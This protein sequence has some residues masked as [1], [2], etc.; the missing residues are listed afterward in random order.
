MPLGFFCNMK[1]KE[2]DYKMDKNLIAQTPA[3]KRDN[4][5]LLAYNINNKTIEH[6]RFFN[7]IDYLQAGDIL[8]LNNSKVISARL[9]GKKETGGKVEVF[10][11]SAAERACG[12]EWRCLV[13][14]GGNK[15]GLEIF[16]AKGLTAKVIGRKEDIFT[17][18]FNQSGRRLQKTIVQI[19]SVPLPPYIKRAEKNK[20]DKKTYQTVYA[21][22][23]KSGS[24]AAPTAG[25]HFTKNILDKLRKKG[26]RIEYVTL[27]VGLGTFQPVKVDDIKKHQMHAEFVAVDKNVIRNIIQAK[28]EGRR[29]IA[30]GTTSARVLESVVADYARAGQIVDI[31]KEV[32]IFIYP[33]YDFKIVD[34]LITNFH[35]P[36][37]TLLMLVAAFLQSKGIK[38][39]VREIKKIYQIAQDKKY[40]FFSYGDAMLVSS[41]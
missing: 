3:K 28:K 41:Y 24:V 40:R 20:D 4:S 18:K 2:F 37:S 1:L 26:V 12:E 33:G 8:V 17:I 34:G 27:H 10:L 31:K 11:L 7:I 39:G 19:G 13:K 30:V 9:M 5:K 14:T 23:K 35:L 38:N 22:D 36:K 32:D 29:I 15:I 6:R 25:L 21:D 16:F